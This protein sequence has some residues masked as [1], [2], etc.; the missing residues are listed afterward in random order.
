MVGVVVVVGATMVLKG[1]PRESYCGR[2]LI[3]RN[4]GDSSEIVLVV[5]QDI[6]C[7]GLN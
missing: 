2:S 5:S 7:G 1:T 6:D 3:S 4:F